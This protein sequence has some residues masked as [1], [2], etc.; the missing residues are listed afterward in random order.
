MGENADI[1][2]K[3]L[4]ILLLREGEIFECGTDNAYGILFFPSVYDVCGSSWAGIDFLRPYQRN[5]V[6]TAK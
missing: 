1:E 2:G 4:D 6:S 3:N 5:Q